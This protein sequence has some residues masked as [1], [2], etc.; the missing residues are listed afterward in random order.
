[1]TLMCGDRWLETG[2]PFAEGDNMNNQSFYMHPRYI[3]FLAFLESVQTDAR[4]NPNA[5]NLAFDVW[6]K[7]KTDN[8]LKNMD[9]AVFSGEQSEQI[10]MLKRDLDRKHRECAERERQCLMLAED[11]ERLNDDLRRARDALAGVLIGLGGQAVGERGDACL[12]ID[13]GNL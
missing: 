9:I 10:A 7:T 2:S 3:E 12:S 11:N 8:M 5:L 4:I 13:G 6:L 1:M